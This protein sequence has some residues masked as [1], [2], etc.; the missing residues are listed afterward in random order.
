MELDKVMKNVAGFKIIIK[1]ILYQFPKVRTIFAI[2]R[3]YVPPSGE[4]KLKT[5]LEILFY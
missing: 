2:Y 5:I 4:Y 1:T 3:L